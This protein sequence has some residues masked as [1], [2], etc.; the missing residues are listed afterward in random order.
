LLIFPNSYQ[1]STNFDFDLKLDRGKYA[2]ISGPA[3]KVAADPPTFN[4]LISYSE[5]GHPVLPTGSPEEREAPWRTQNT[6]QY[7]FGSLLKPVSNGVLE[8]LIPD[9]NTSAD[10]VDPPAGRPHAL[11]LL[12]P[13]QQ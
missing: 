6:T 10:G 3:K 8:L 2:Y 1:I 9:D 12:E 4:W 7:V 13:I 5:L 11:V